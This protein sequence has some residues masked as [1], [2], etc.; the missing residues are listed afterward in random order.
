MTNEDK[1][2]AVLKGSYAKRVMFPYE[3]RLEQLQKLERG[4]LELTR[5]FRDAVYEDLGRSRN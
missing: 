1:I 3:K 5:D 2:L 4:L